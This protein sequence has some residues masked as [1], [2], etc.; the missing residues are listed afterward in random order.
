MLFA[1][2]TLEVW[3][4][5]RSSTLALAL[6]MA[7]SLG[8]VGAAPASAAKGSLGTTPLAQVAPQATDLPLAKPKKKRRWKAPRGPHFN[9]PHRK[10]G[11]LRIERKL[12]KTINH[13]PK[14]ST[15]RIAVYSFDRH[16][17][18]RAL[19]RAYR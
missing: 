12:I 16:Q 19:V 5:T 13:A 4:V 6:W 17:V 8:L 2:S 14:R 7:L 18:A 3:F 10:T 11:H 9:D 1:H 15:I